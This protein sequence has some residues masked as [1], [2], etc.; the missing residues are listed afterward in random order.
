MRGKN[1]RIEFSRRGVETR[2]CGSMVMGDTTGLQA[3][4][5]AKKDEFYTQRVDIEN[6]LRH[7]KPHF[8]RK[9]VI[10]NC[11]TVGVEATYCHML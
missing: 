11:D 8:K 5:R 2:S 1:F 9:V 10:C 4:K 3:A 6:E 7:Y